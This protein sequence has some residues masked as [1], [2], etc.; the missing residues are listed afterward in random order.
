MGMANGV[1]ALGSRYRPN[2]LLLVLGDCGRVE[3]MAVNPYLII[4]VLSSKNTYPRN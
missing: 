4:E 2:F 1:E 3:A